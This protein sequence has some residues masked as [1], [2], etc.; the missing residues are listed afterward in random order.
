MAVAL[1]ACSGALL[2]VGT[3]LEAAEAGVGTHVRLGLPACGFLRVTGS[4][5][6]TCGMT[7]A[8]TLAVHGRLLA[9]FA[10]QPAGAL[11]A[12]AVASITLLSA[13]ALV[14]GL[15]LAPL[16]SLLWRPRPLLS[17][18]LFVVVAWVYKMILM[19]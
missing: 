13:Y 6:A 11:F 18:G 7:T 2:A 12:V 15:N 14:A 1:L 19:Q 17:I 4:P 9:A 16:G 8:F 5:C 10:T 3:A